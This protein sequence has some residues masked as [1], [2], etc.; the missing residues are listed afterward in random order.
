MSDPKEIYLSPPCCSDM[1]GEG[2]LWCENDEWPE[3][4]CGTP[5]EHRPATRYV[6]AD[7]HEAALKRQAGAARTLQASTLEAV[8][9]LHEKDRSEYTA[10][11]ALESE[12]EVNALLTAENERLRTLNAEMREALRGLLELVQD[13]PNET[14]LAFGIT[15][16]APHLKV[17]GSTRGVI[18]RARAALKQAEAVP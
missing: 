4:D 10:G 12:R 6:R 18:A 9:H 17:D 13:Q 5:E 1:I 16:I 7:I 3:G 8:R 2:Q 15:E 14:D 11:A